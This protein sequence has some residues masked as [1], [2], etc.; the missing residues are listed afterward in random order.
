[1]F[2]V[3]HSGMSKIAPRWAGSR[4]GF[5]KMEIQA[6]AP[7]FDSFYSIY[8][9]HT[10]KAEAE[11][12]FNALTLELQQRA[13]LD[14]MRRKAEH[15]PWREK[16]FVPNPARYLRRH[17]WTD[18]IIPYKSTEQQLA[19]LEDG[20]IHSRFWTMLVQIYGKR[21]TREYGETMPAAWRFGLKGITE[22]Q[23]ARTLAGLVAEGDPYLPNLPTV[24][25]ILANTAP[26]P[27]LKML[28]HEPQQTEEIFED[29]WKQLRGI[30]KY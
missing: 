16:K 17:L 1:M 10:N 24:K 25:R 23:A 30:L 13:I 28:K 8:P 27:R 7:T 12:L 2:H 19:E 5:S 15:E 22:E 4:Y 26:T 18:E 20:S 3:E 14:V 29:G 6:T 21:I 9:K 11:K